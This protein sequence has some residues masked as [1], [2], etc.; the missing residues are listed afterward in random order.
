MQARLESGRSRAQSVFPELRSQQE[1]EPGIAA[2]PVRPTGL[3]MQSLLAPG[4]SLRATTLS[5]LNLHHH[6]DL[7]VRYLRARH[8]VFI[9]D[10]NWNL[11]EIDGMEFDQYDTPV[12]RWIVVHERGEVLAGI[13][14]TPT[15]ARCGLHSY[16]IRDAQLGLLDDLQADVLYFRAPESEHLW[17]ASRLFVAPTV[18]AGRR[19]DVQQ[20]LMYQMA[21]AA[22]AVGATHVIGIVPAVFK[23]WMKRI[24][25]NATAV[26]PVI[27][28]AADLSRAALMN[29]A[30]LVTP[31]DTGKKVGV[32]S[33]AS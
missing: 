16:M 21:I 10:K 27:R 24:G 12:A 31:P 15:T 3:D 14:I 2:I 23:R 19:A 6:G 28:F 17:E 5:M 30:E 13:R 33:G 25:M 4:E 7:F 1:C 22:Q 32:C 11:P 26:G 29:V 18:D 20:L 8:D 9:R